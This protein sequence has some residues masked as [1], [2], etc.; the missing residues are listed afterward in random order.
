MVLHTELAIPSE[1]CCI[2]FV[3]KNAS[4]TAWESKGKIDFDDDAGRFPLGIS[5]FLVSIGTLI[6]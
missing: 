1:R 2:P 4:E 6:S 5:Y 3:S